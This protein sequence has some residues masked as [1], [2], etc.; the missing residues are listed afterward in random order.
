MAVLVITPEVE[1]ACSELVKWASQRDNWYI[2]DYSAIPGDDPRHVIQLMS[3]RVVFSI[4]LADNRPYRHLS[5]STNGHSGGPPRL[6]HP[7]IVEEIAHLFGFTGQ[8]SDWDLDVPDDQSCVVVC[9]TL[10]PVAEDAHEP[11]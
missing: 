7:V 2:P 4:T 9:Q 10:Y 3:C 1:A 8:M 5:I 11:Y 6:P